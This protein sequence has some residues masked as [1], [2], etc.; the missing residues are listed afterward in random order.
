MSLYTVYYSPFP[1]NIYFGS[2]VNAL[3]Q[4]EKIRLLSNFCT[5]YQPMNLIER[6]Q[7]SVFSLLNWCFESLVQQ[8]KRI[9]QLCQNGDHTKNL[10]KNKTFPRAFVKKMS[11]F[12]V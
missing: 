1:L 12:D 5:A 7:Y 2:F 4:S 10:R 11:C 3:I 6:E 8:H 9:Q